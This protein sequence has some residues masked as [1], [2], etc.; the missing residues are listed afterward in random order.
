MSDFI[1]TSKPA[2]MWCWDPSRREWSW[3]P[4]K[5]GPRWEAFMKGFND[6]LRGA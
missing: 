3:I 6:G 2:G 5:S 1:M 4:A